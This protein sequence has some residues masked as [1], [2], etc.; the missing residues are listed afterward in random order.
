[1]HLLI[2]SPDQQI[3]SGEVKSVTAPGS[4]GQFQVLNNH[5][6]LVSALAP[7]RIEVVGE[8]G[9]KLSWTIGGG[10]AEV[11]NNEIA[12]LVSGVKA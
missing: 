10:F 9:E 2:L 4:D 12:L 8:N 5:A 6:A 1:M 11:L 3:F 7:G